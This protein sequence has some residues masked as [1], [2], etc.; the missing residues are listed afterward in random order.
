MTTCKL[1]VNLNLKKFPFIQEIMHLHDR[2]QVLESIECIKRKNEN[3]KTFSRK[4][5][6]YM[7]GTLFMSMKYYICQEVHP[8]YS[9]IIC[10][11]MFKL[12]PNGPYIQETKLGW[13]VAGGNAHNEKTELNS[14]MLKCKEH[15]N[16]YI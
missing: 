9:D 2:C 13:I 11:N 10:T 15:D 8:I 7:S 16:M 3:N 1:L 6:R 4:L 12:N 14:C 5:H